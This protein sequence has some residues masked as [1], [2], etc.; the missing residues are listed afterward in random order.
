[1]KVAAH[2]VAWSYGVD[3]AL[4]AAKM[5]P[6]VFR[7]AFLYEAGRHTHLHGDLLDIYF[8]D[9][10]IMFGGLQQVISDHGVI[11]GTERMVD[12]SACREGFFQNQVITDKAIQLENASTLPFQLQQSSSQEVS[13][14]DI[15]TF[16]F[17]I[18]FSL[19]ALTRDLF[20]VSTD[21][22]YQCSSN[23]TLTI[24]EGAT[25]MLPIEAPHQFVDAVMAF[26][27]R[28]NKN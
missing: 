19:G 8:T 22:A 28:A 12:T 4:L 15:G 13:C 11:A 24:L 26:L 1:V 5:N 27:R 23:G 10:S 2:V 14:A 9:A 7:S 17:P 21:G 20:R 6:D 18:C 3:V 25:H 16:T